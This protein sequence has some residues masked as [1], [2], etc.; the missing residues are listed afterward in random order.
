[1]EAVDLALGRILKAVE[2]VNGILLVTADHGNADEMYDKP[3]EGEKVHKAKTSHT[4]NKVPFIVYGA[5]V[6]LKHDDDMG[7]SDIAATVCQLLDVKPNENWR[8]SI[9]EEMK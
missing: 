9:I 2:K 6:K 4:L 5:D 1:M 8:P 7:L 3:K